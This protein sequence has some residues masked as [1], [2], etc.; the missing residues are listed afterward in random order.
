M[1]K[2]GNQWCDFIIDLN[3]SLEYWQGGTLHH[4]KPTSGNTIPHP[5][6]GKEVGKTVPIST[7]SVTVQS[8]KNSGQI[9]L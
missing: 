5:Y 9:K 3:N 8:F 4:T 7:V 1:G 6:A 2:T